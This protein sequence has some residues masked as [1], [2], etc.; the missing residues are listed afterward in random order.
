MRGL[1]PGLIAAGTIL[2]TAAIAQTTAGDANAGHRFALASCSGCHL[3]DDQQK[4]PAV[5][6]VPSYQ[7]L[8]NDASKTPE[9]LRTFLASPHGAMPPLSLSRQ[10]IDDVVA[11]IG[12]L[13]K[14]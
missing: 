9:R 14:P 3:V 1:L 12:T 6:G 10:E 5:D 2:A 4:K 11:Y 7:S 13:K 8:A